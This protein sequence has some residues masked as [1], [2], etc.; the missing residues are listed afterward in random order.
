MDQAVQTKITTN[1]AV[2]YGSGYGYGLWTGQGDDANVVFAMGWGGQFIMVVP[3]R[4]LVVVATNQ[5][6]GL[7]YAIASAQWSRTI[8]LI[9][10]EILPAFE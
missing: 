6:S 3:D 2:Y 4:G 10:M 8:D 1:N 7:T 5:W 9:M